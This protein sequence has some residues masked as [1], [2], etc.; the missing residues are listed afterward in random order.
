[1]VITKCPFCSYEETKVLETREAEGAIKRRREC[2]KCGK[3]FVTYERPSVDIIVIKKDGRRED[4]NREK[5][6]TG[7]KKACEKRPIGYDK[8][9]KMVDKVERE[10]RKTGQKEIESSVIGEM[11]VKK[12]KKLDKVA[13]IRF[14]SVYRSFE[15]IES[16]ENEISSLKEVKK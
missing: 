5:I 15:D 16:F 3:R 8:I 1:M 11:I 10:I 7:I 14:A 9:E 13:Y 4:F 6:L 2:E 12:L